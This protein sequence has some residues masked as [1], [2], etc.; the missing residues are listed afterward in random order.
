MT[1]QPC[2]RLEMKSVREDR[3]LFRAVYAD[4][5]IVVVDKRSGGLV[6]RTPT[7]KEPTLID[8]VAAAYGF[9]H[10]VHRLDR[11]VSGL[12]V[13]GRDEAA[14]THLRAQFA[15]HQADRRYLAGIEGQLSASDG[16]FRSRLRLEG[17]TFGVRAVKSGPGRDAVT[18][19]WTVEAFEAAGATLVEVALET[20]VKN[21]IRVHFADAGHP[22][23]G[24][25]KYLPPDRA[26]ARTT[27]RRRLFLHAA[28]LS[29]R[30]PDDDRELS[31][32]APLPGDLSRWKGNLRRGEPVPAG[33]TAK[34]K[35]GPPSPPGRRAG[36]S[37]GPSSRQ[38]PSRRR[39]RR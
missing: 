27:Q 6:H 12:L 34:G 29:L 30:H 32:R 1:I 20:G 5:R 4:D 36:S 3:P 28:E 22:I 9:V 26:G 33:R 35:S 18:H 31:F 11:F 24:E 21:Q 10:P 19:W 8:H 13:Y 7:S 17:P 25:Q 37:R 16:V 23:L 2:Y 15:S 39:K 38:S 14:A